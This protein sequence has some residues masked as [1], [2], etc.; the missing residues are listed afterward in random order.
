MLSFRFS[1]LSPTTP[2]TRSLISSSLATSPGVSLFSV[3]EKAR[4]LAIVAR[5][6]C[7]F[8][9]EMSERS[10]ESRSMFARIRPKRCSFPVTTVR[11]AAVVAWTSRRM[12]PSAFFPSSVPKVEESASVNFFT[13]S[14]I[15]DSFLHHL[16]EIHGVQGVCDLPPRRQDALR[17]L[18]REDLDVFLAEE[19]L[20]LDG[21]DRVDRD[22]DPLLDAEDEAGAVSRRARSPRLSRSEPRPSS[23]PTWAPDPTPCRSLP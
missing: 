22:P 8:A 2:L 1:R 21:T 4:R 9:E 10:A 13:S 18:A 7:L 14:P 19:A 17:V 11:R 15:A 20:R 16:V 23:R 5:T 12:S 6:S 3:S